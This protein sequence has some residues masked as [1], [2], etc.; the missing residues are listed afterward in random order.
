MKRKLSDVMSSGNTRRPDYSESLALTHLL[1][2]IDDTVGNMNDQFDHT[3][4]SEYMTEEIRITIGGRSV[5]LL[6]GGP[7][8]AALHNMIEHI[9]LE[10]GYIVDHFN[11][12]VTD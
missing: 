8:I 3:N 5:A 10:N 9:A 7:Q 4:D 6:L 12:E 1:D 2:I 11:N